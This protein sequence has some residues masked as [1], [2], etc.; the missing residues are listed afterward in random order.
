MRMIV[1]P[2]TASP[3]RIARWTGTTFDGKTFFEELSSR[4]VKMPAG[5]DGD[6]FFAEIASRGVSMPAMIVMQK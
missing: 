6:K 3:A 1:T 5:F 4:G 2:L